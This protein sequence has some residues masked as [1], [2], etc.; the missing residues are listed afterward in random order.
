MTYIVDDLYSLQSMWSMTYI[1][2]D[3]FKSMP[4]EVMMVDYDWSC[5]ST[6]Y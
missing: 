2:Y 6:H 3:L 5:N 1:V 4:L